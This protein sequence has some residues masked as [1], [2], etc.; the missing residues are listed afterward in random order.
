MTAT[1]AATPAATPAD[2]TPVPTVVPTVE[3]PTTLLDTAAKPDV[4]PDIAPAAV[5]A[6][7]P[8]VKPDS[9]VPEKYEL[10]LPKDATGIDPAIVERTAAIARVQ[11]L[12][13]EGGQKLLESV[14]AEIRVQDDARVSAWQPGGASWKARDT[15]WRQAALADPEIGGSPE[16]LATSVELANKVRTTLGGKDFDEFLLTTGLGSHPA[17]LK[18]LAKIG[19]AMSE[20]TL[21]LGPSTPGG[22]KIPTHEALYGPDGMGRKTAGE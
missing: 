19:R 8:A 12:S 13:N 16:K 15:E 18:F 10:V 11:G 22:G 7:V 4:P 3:V 6:A 17:A 2:T 5:P 1:T 21:K 20:S 9:V 14:V